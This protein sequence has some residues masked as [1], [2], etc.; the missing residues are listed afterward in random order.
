MTARVK[1]ELRPI[2]TRRQQLAQQP[3]LHIII[4]AVVIAASN[5]SE[6][7]KAIKEP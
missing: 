6:R 2:A 3:K 4:A 1:S 7:V 5:D